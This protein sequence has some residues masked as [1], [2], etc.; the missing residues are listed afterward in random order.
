MKNTGLLSTSIN[1]ESYRNDQRED[2]AIEARERKRI[3]TGS[4]TAS[5]R[6]SGPRD[7]HS[8]E[9]RRASAEPDVRGRS[10]T[11]SALC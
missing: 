11:E 10:S 8:Y 9:G 3:E 2:K 1:G 7:D 6:M 4:G 5:T